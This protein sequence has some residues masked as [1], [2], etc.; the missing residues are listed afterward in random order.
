M[1]F[2]IKKCIFAAA[3]QSASEIII[4]LRQVAQSANALSFDL[5][6]EYFSALEQ[7]EILGGNLCL[8]LQVKEQAYECFVLKMFIEGD[9]RVA[10]DRC[11]DDLI[12]SVRETGEVKI[13]AG[14]SDFVTD[15]DVK[16]PIGGG[17]KYDVAWDVYETI[18]LSLPLQRMHAIQECNPDIVAMISNEEENLDNEI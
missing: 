12:L 16:T 15:E 11:M 3:M 2:I 18:L 1:F 17:Y 13:Y 10:C 14:N 7:D 6:D 4:D 8:N 9:V 5:A